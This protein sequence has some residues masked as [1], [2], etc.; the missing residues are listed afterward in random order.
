MHSPE[1]QNGIKY[2]YKIYL[3]VRSQTNMAKVSSEKWLLSDCY[4]LLTV[5]SDTAIICL[6]LCLC[7]ISDD[8]TLQQRKRHYAYWPI[9]RSS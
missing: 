2:L 5:T 4:A 7:I 1:K 3:K 8:K 9:T 6:L